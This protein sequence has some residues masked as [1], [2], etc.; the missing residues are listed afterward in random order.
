MQEHNIKP[1]FTSQ[2]AEILAKYVSS[3]RVVVKKEK[4]IDVVTL[5]DDE[6]LKIEI[7]DED[8]ILWLFSCEFYE[9]RGNDE[10]V[11]ETVDYQLELI[12]TNPITTVKTYKANKLI[13]AE[14][15][16]NEEYYGTEYMHWFWALTHFGEKR[17][18]TTIINYDPIGGRFN[19]IIQ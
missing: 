11:L 14:Y 6:S 5:C 13:K 16:I 12:F 19:E 4:K 3:E 15:K 7:S 2:I 10:E 17:E 1:D 9:L 18:E 8:L